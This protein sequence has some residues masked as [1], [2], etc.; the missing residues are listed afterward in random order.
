MLSSTVYGHYDA[1]PKAGSPLIDSAASV[2]ELDR[3]FFGHP[4][5]GDTKIDIGAIEV[6]TATGVAHPP[7]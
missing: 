5:K 7:R 3:D 1:T 2:P 4:R 6:Q